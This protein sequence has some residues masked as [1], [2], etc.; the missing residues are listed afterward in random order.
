MVVKRR[1]RISPANGKRN[2]GGEEEEKEETA[3]SPAFIG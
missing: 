2:G 3:T 1:S